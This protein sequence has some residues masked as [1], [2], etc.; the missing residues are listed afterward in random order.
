MPTI[1]SPSSAAAPPMKS[2]PVTTI[3]PVKP[4]RVL[5]KSTAAGIAV[6][7]G[8]LAAGVRMEGGQ[9]I[10]LLQPTAALIVFGGTAGAVMVQFPS[11]VMVQAVRSLSTVLYQVD[12]STR[13][14]IAHLA[15]FCRKAR[16][17]GTLSLDHEVEALRDPFLK[18]ALQLAVDGADAGRVREIMTA[19]MEALEESEEQVPHVLECA[20]GYAPTIGIIGAVL[21]LIQVLGHL[22]EVS[23][24]GR[25]IAAAFVAT[26]YGVGAANL[27]FLP[28]AGKLKAR[29]RQRQLMREM[30]LEGVIGIVNGEHPRMLE[31]RLIT[32]RRERTDKELKLNER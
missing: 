27:F 5:D 2:K 23:A 9:L 18:R 7:L 20:G 8:C 25:G 13:S 12:D 30:I 24:L 22:G 14:T 19:E 11:P 28:A 31:A 1:S 32:F 4:V 21:G 15:E 10:Q 17:S 26:L 29:L 3:A 6:A 16:R